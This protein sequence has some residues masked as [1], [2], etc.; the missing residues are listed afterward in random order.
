MSALWGTF[1]QIPVR[2]R[3]ETGLASFDFVDLDA[4]EYS[5]EI[6]GLKHSA[7]SVTDILLQFSAD[8]VAWDDNPAHY[9]VGGNSAGFAGACLHQGLPPDTFFS[10]IYEI[11]CFDLAEASWVA[12]AG[13]RFSSNLGARNPSTY[14]DQPTVWTGIR[15]ANSAGHPFTTNLGL[16]LREKRPY[17]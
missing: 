16:L 10:G 11:D 8:G 14:N 17:R 9:I 13:G 2:R 1:S 15:I 3:M 6:L 12:M 5:L 7:G 4:R